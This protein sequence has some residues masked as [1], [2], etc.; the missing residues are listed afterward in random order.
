MPHIPPD[1]TSPHP[2]EQR[3]ATTVVGSMHSDPGHGQPGAARVPPRLLDG[4]ISDE[5]LQLELGIIDRTTRKWRQ[6][7]S[8]PPFVKIGRDYYYPIEGFKAWLKK[9]TATA[10]PLAGEAVR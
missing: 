7:G 10:T 4:Y 8:G 3:T 5:D 6:T 2:G 1:Q 9:R